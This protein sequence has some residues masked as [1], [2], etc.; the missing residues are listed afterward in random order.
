MPFGA[1]VARGA[2]NPAGQRGR[3]LHPGRHLRLVEIVLVDVDPAR[4]LPR[5]SGWNG[6]Q[7]RASE[8]GHLDVVR[9]GMEGD[10]P[11]LALDAV[12]GRVPPHGLAHAGDV[13]HDER[14]EASPDVA[15]PAR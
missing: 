2:R 5:A 4:V 9:E 1:S 12:E 8:E 6:S 7:R 13:A 3:L 14:V 10:E 11:A 15:F